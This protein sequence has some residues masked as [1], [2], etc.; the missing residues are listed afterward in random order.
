MTS[1]NLLNVFLVLVLAG[2]VALAVY[3]PGK[4]EK[5]SATTITQLDVGA[6]QTLRIEIPGSPALVLERQA[7]Q[8]RMQAPFVMPANNGRIHQLLKVAQ[9]KSVASYPMGRVD[10]KQ[11]QLDAPMLL[12]TLN[13]LSLRFG[14]TT[15]LGDNRYVQVGDTVHLITDRYSHLARTAASEFVSPALLPANTK[16][17]QLQLASGVLAM[18]DDSAQTLF[19][20]WMHARALKV[21]ALQKSEA[22]TE[23]I[24][25]TVESAESL[26]FDVLRGETE[27]ILQRPA[28]GLQYHFPVE[29]GQR[30]ITLPVPKPATAE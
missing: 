25:L 26:R 16:I 12:L 17:S 30:L 18:Q 4:P 13:D 15:A 27:I 21:S 1:R 29:T 6:I 7:E 14:T 23:S 3:E 5:P 10:V 11:L 9:A 28:V 19:A 20:E 2:L 22:I 24:V 8:W